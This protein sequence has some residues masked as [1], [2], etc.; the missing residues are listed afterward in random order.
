MSTSYLYIVAAFVIVAIVLQF[1]LR[2]V[3]K[4][5]NVSVSKAA[6]GDMSAQ[7]VMAEYLESV[8]ENFDSSKFSLVWAGTFANVDI[9]RIVAY[10][11]RQILMV[12][13][14]PGGAPL[15]MPK[16]QP[17][18]A[19][20]LED[21]DH[22]RLSRKQSITRMPYVQLFFSE[23]DSDDNLDIWQEKKN[24]YGEPNTENF[25]RFIDFIA[26]WAAAKGV[27]VEVQ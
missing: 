13:A 23:T 9:T 16:D 19:V 3:L 7:E 26:D 20:N 1:G 8:L 17:F 6:S 5:K 21:V 15:T 24:F 2:S 27:K 12:P 4:K 10:N 11:D 25:A 22:I 14:I 18:V